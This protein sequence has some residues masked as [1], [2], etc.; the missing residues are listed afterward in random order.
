[1]AISSIKQVLPGERLQAV[2]LGAPSL[3]TYY[4][5]VGKFQAEDQPPTLQ[6]MIKLSSIYY[7]ND[8]KEEAIRLD[9]QVRKKFEPHRLSFHPSLLIHR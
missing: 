7:N 5:R 8:R 4:S 1:M 9:E 3:D 2:T 6:S